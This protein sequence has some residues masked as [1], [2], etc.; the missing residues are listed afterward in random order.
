MLIECKLHR[1]GGTV[2]EIGGREYHFKPDVDGRHVCIVPTEVGERLL[3]IPEAYAKATARTT[4]EPLAK[5]LSVAPL[6]NLTP[7]VPA[8]ASRNL[9][10]MSRPELDA[11]ARALGM[12]VRGKPSDERL[13]V[14]IALFLAE[15]SELND[16]PPTTGEAD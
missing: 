1:P 6:V 4:G 5:P 7:E 11:Y 9:A 2:V 15:R 8:G 12:P 16:E 13:R 3:E 10:E 14:N